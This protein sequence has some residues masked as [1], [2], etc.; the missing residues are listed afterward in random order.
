[1]D[2]PYVHT[3]YPD[4]SFLPVKWPCYSSRRNLISKYSFKNNGLKGSPKMAGVIDGRP[5]IFIMWPQA[6]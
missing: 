6:T 2:T 1:M 3:A 5:I 4:S